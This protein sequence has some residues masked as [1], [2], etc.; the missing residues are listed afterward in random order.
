ML[1]G[2]SGTCCSGK[3]TLIAYLIEKYGFTQLYING[4]ECP[5]DF[6]SFKSAINYATSNW[7]SLF[8]ISDIE[9]YQDVDS[10][11]KRPFFLLLFIDAPVSVRYQRFLTKNINE[12]FQS[13]SIDNTQCTLEKFIAL[14]EDHLYRTTGLYSAHE[15]SQRAQ[16]RLLNGSS[17]TKHFQSQIE[18]LNLL[19]PELTRP[20]WD[21][22]F[23]ALCELAS[24]RSNCMKRRNSLLE[25]GR[26]RIANRN[27]TLYCTTCPC[28]GCAKKIIQVGISKVVYAHD[29]GMDELT[30]KLFQQAGIE[31][32]QVPPQSINFV[33]NL[34]C[35]D[36]LIK[37]MR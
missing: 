1:L 10:A 30:A 27:V 37:I 32:Q 33:S 18:N 20:S 3:K 16:L 2:I 11:F 28:L 36:N 7:R 8:L 9:K 35:D 15:I 23:M 26:D 24:Q 19:N 4:S 25:A 17:D 5:T 34:E 29:Y 12:N 14:D 31:I 13:L 22:Y 6:V 21:T